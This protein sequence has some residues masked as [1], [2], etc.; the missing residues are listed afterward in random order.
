LTQTRDEIALWLAQDAAAQARASA[1]PGS[2]GPARAMGSTA[3]RLA[4]VAL[5]AVADGL[6]HRGSQSPTQTLVHA[7]GD[8]SH[9][10]LLPTARSHPWALVGSAA[11]GGALLALGC[12]S[13]F[14]PTGWGRWVAQWALPSLT[15]AAM[16]ALRPTRHPAD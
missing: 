13:A 4:G 12:R 15:R 11:L 5:G 14:R 6:M 10:L 2:A 3:N 7:A 9:A 1:E 8:A 16:Q